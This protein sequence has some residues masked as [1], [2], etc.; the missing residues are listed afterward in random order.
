MR[1][2]VATLIILF[3]GQFAYTQPDKRLELV[4]FDY[5]A[6]SIGSGDEVGISWS[7]SVESY[8]SYKV[9]CRVVLSLTTAVGERREFSSA[10]I[11]LM[12]LGS[13]SLSGEFHLPRELWDVAEVVEVEAVE[14]EVDSHIEQPNPQ[15]EGEA[16]LERCKE[17]SRSDPD[18]YRYQ[19]N[20]IAE[21]EGEIK[22]IQ[23]LIA[24]VQMAEDKVIP[25]RK[26][27]EWELEKWELEREL[28]SMVDN[29]ERAIDA[30]CTELHGENEYHNRRQ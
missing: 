12:G 24:E 2:I 4:A 9:K 28:A 18:A 1:C 19:K 25:R 11:D 29:L 5:N 26:V 30:Y 20:L 8:L 23:G 14:G 22:R 6:I 17:E 21:K 10:P 13:A 27:K 15:F 7:G 16:H 3:L